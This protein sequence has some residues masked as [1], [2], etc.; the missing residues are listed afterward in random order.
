[1]VETENVQRRTLEELCDVLTG[2]KLN[3]TETLDVVIQF[4]YSI[5]ASME[6]EYNL[7]SS[8][9]VLRSYAENPSIGNALMAQALWMRDTWKGQVR[10]ENE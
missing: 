9:A 8:E 2:A 7:Q 10:E 4:L 6:P 1:M 5:G 3:K